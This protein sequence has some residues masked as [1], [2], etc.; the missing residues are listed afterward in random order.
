[1]PSTDT[2]RRVHGLTR[3]G[4]RAK[5]R[6][7]EVNGSSQFS[8]KSQRAIPGNGLRHWWDLWYRGQRILCKLQNRLG[9]RRSNSPVQHYLVY[10]VIYKQIHVLATT[11]AALLASPI[12]E[13]PRS[14]EL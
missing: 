13:P 14:S 5:Q 9:R 4:V 12:R 1:M 3:R 2:G 8:P 11:A 10:S 6:L 7:V